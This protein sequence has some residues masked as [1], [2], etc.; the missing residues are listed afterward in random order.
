MRQHFGGKAHRDAFNAH[1]DALNT[2]LGKNLMPTVVVNFAGVIKGMSKFDNMR[3]AV[4]TELARL[5][6]EANGIADKIQAN[7]AAIAQADHDF[8][9]S[10]SAILVQKEPEFVGMV[11]KNRIA[12]HA[13]K[14]AAR[15]EATRARIRQEE[16]D[17]LAR[18]QAERDRIE[19]KRVAD[20]AAQTALQSAGAALLAARVPVPAP[21]A[22]AIT[23]ITDFAPAAATV[24]VIHQPAKKVKPP[25]MS[26]GEISTRLGFNVTSAFLAS[27]GF[28]ATTVRAAKL[29]HDDDFPRIC[30]ALVDH[31]NSVCETA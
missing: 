1:I 13:A 10:D 29:Y 21:E 8:L 31:I 9:F 20:E 22:P 25:T 27:L 23:K 16:I 12:D 30:A 5:K 11:I 28:E 24:R 17:R 6:I 14:E 3:D 4:A 18:E 26:L 15:I 2:R 7:I 19:A